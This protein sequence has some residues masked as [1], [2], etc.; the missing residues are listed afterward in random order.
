MDW[1]VVCPLIILLIFGVCII[2]YIVKKVKRSAEEAIARANRLMADM[3]DAGSDLVEIR[4]QIKELSGI[5]YEIE[6][7][8]D[9]IETDEKDYGKE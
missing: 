3:D 1:I 9:S 2:S 4:Q 5:L 8:I 7:T 6:E